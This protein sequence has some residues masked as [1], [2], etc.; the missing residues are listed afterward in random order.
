MNP[1][2]SRDLE[3][4]RPTIPHAGHFLSMEQPE[5]MGA[6][7]LAFLSPDEQGG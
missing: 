2:P 1:L 5:G 7:V 4:A 6:R 3:R